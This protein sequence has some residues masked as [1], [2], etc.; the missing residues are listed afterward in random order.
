[1]FPLFQTE[2]GNL[3]IHT[4]ATDSRRI[5]GHIT[6]ADNH[7]ITFKRKAFFRSRFPQE[8]NGCIS[9]FCIFS[10][11]TRFSSTLAS[12][13]HVETFVS[14]FAQFFDRDVFSDLHT[15]ADLH[16]K[17]PDHIDLCCQKVFL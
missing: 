14:L 9:T 16:A 6:T 15:T 12:D 5:D 4:T 17:F 1:M 7:N 3:R 11:D 2:H 10:C 8:I 13:R